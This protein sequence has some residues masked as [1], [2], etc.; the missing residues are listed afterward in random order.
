M[1]CSENSAVPP[2]YPAE[3]IERYYQRGL[4]EKIVRMKIEDYRTRHMGKYPAR[5]FVSTSMFVKINEYM[6][7]NVQA[8]VLGGSKLFGI[9]VSIIQ[10]DGGAGIYL[11]DE[12]EED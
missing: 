5:I 11:S 6:E 10:D 2:I 7:F 1:R 8:C 3:M 9:P 12:E 4:F